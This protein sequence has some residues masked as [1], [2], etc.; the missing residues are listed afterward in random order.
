M[1]IVEEQ[2]TK[3]VKEI[4]INKNQHA[5]IRI[6]MHL[7]IAWGI[8]QRYNKCIQEHKTACRKLVFV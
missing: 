4:T 7:V 8:F 5:K 3:K 2:I 6:C 1:W